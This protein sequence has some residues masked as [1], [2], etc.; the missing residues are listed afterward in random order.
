MA[1]AARHKKDYYLIGI[2]RWGS[3]RKSN[4][5][6]SEGGEGK[7][8]EFFSFFLLKYTSKANY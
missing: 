4:D 6:E 8:N 5:H 7:K 3:T 1:S 2:I